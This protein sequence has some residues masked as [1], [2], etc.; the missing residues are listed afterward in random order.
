[1]LK[2]IYTIVQLV[3]QALKYVYVGFKNAVPGYTRT[4]KFCSRFWQKLCDVTLFIFSWEFWQKLRHVKVLSKGFWQKLRH[5]FAVFGEKKPILLLESKKP[6]LLLESKKPIMDYHRTFQL[7]YD[8]L[9][10]L[11]NNFIPLSAT[12]NIKRYIEFKM[13]KKHVEWLTSFEKGYNLFDIKLFE[14]LLVNYLVTTLPTI[15]ITALI[16][17]CASDDLNLTFIKT[18]LWVQNVDVDSFV[19][20]VTS[21]SKKNRELLTYEAVFGINQKAYKQ[22]VPFSSLPCLDLFVKPFPFGLRVIALFKNGQH[23]AFLPTTCHTDDIISLNEILTEI[24]IYIEE[25]YS[26]SSQAIEGFSFIITVPN[27]NPQSHYFLK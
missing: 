22:P 3:A 8:M 27:L 18:M 13:V 15:A 25:K 12:H 16:A 19:E 2:Y 4:F 20:M 5:S 23:K 17:K 11:F 14:H 21:Y 6:I 9:Q 26:I 10:H 24:I 7:K 1:M